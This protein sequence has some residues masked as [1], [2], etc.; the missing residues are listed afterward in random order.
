MD[1]F[2]YS[3]TDDQTE[4][5][6]PDCKKIYFMQFNKGD[7]CHTQSVAMLVWGENNECLLIYYKRDLL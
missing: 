3:N 6:F 5:H 7:T 1:I 4:N 2:F